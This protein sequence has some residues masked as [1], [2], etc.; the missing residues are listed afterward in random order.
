MLGLA[1][2]CSARCITLAISRAQ[3]TDENRFVVTEQK[4]AV[5]QWSCRSGGIDFGVRRPATSAGTSQVE[6]ARDVLTATIESRMLFRSVAHHGFSCLI[7][8]DIVHLQLTAVSDPV[9]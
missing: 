3:P 8:S 5:Q 9:F 6:D 1:F 7:I 2:L 4:V